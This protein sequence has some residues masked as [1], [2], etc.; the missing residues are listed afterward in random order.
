MN[1]SHPCLSMMPLALLLALS[2]LGTGCD[3]SKEKGSPGT[4]P[5][6]TV[7]GT[8][9]DTL[10]SA[11]VKSALLAD[12]E[13]K[14]LDFNVVTH[15]GEVQLSG[16]VENQAQLDRAMEITRN[17]E[18]VKT[19]DDRTAR[20]TAATP[21]FSERMDDGVMIA[22]IRAGLLA[23]AETRGGNISVTTHLGEVQLSGFVESE[24]Q[25]ARAVEIAQAVQGV[26]KVDNQLSIKK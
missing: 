11:Q 4:N 17:I 10:L 12:P 25:M 3:Q 15:K 26:Q 5:L 7:N 20:K 9:D 6:A 18:G 19:V 24:K 2:S 23:D 13:I 14:A 8:I 21:N 16:F 1:K 22:S